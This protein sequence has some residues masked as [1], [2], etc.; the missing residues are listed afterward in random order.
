MAG[1]YPTQKSLDLDDGPRVRVFRAL[2][3]VLRND[4]TL[5]RVIG[6]KSW[7]TYNGTPADKQPFGAT[8]APAIVLYPV[9]GPEGFWS[10]DAMVGDLHVRVELTVRG[11]CVDDADNLYWAIER[12]IYPQ[13]QASKLAVNAALKAAGAHTGIVLFTMPAFDPRADAASDGL[14]QASGELKVQIRNSFT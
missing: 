3:Q 4:P 13:D 12:A 7:R 10:P 9:P 1:P 2:E 11:T 8:S 6:P 14:L 5:R